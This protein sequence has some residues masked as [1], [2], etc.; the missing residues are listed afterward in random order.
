MNLL[1]EISGNDQL[2]KVFHHINEEVK[3]T[4]EKIEGV[5]SSM[6]NLLGTFGAGFAAF[7]MGDLI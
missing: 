1:F 3:E 7:E 2:S 6:K 4:K 5:H